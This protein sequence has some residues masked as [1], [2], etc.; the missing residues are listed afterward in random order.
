V[1]GVSAF[2]AQTGVSWVTLL[3]RKRGHV[4]GHRTTQHP[5][6]EDIT[7]LK[8]AL[9][10]QV[11]TVED[12]SRDVARLEREVTELRASVLELLVET[13]VVSE[14]DNNDIVVC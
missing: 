7:M 13:A 5:G 3:Q 11:S 2:H 12:L 8:T 10:A 1:G 6:N 4:Y 9:N 14:S